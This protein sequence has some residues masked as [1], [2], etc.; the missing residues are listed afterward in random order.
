M[1]RALRTGL[2]FALLLLLGFAPTVGA[3]GLPDQDLDGVS[4]FEDCAP[5][6]PRLTT[7]HTYYIE[8]DGDG[9][10]DAHGAVQHCGVQPFPG[11][12]IWGWDPDDSDNTII[13][14]IVRKNSRVLGL[15]F[16]DS[17]SNGIRA[18]KL[19]R[20]LGAEATMLPLVWSF[21]ESAPGVFDGPQAQLLRAINDDLAADG[22]VA[23]LTVSPIVE[24]QL[25]IPTDLA[26]ALREGTIRFND[27]VFVARFKGLLHF[28]RS[29]LPDL[30]VIVLDIGH[31][32]DR[33][34]V[35]QPDPQFWGDFHHF[36]GQ[37]SPYA[38]ALWG[39][40][41]AIA[42]NASHRGLMTQPSA[43]L[44]DALNTAADVVSVTYFPRNPN[45]TAI[46]PQ[47]VHGQIEELLG[48]Y[49]D[50]AF[51]FQ[52]VGYPTSPALFSSATMQSQFL[53]AFFQVWDQ[54]AERVRSACFTRLYDWTLQRALAE[55][56][57][58]IHG[59]TPQTIE[60]ATAYFQTLGLRAFEGAGAA[61]TG[62]HS[63]RNLAFERNWWR[64]APP[65]SRSFLLGMTP[66]PYDLNPGGPLI[67]EVMDNMFAAIGNDVDLVAHHFD[68]G[69]PWTEA[70]AD[71]F[72]SPELPY[73]AHLK[74]SWAKHRDR[75]PP[76]I[77][78][79]VSVNALGIPRNVLAPYWGFGEGFYHDDNFQA[80][81]TGVFQDYRD[82]LLP[83]PFDSL[84]LDSDVVRTAFLNY[85]RRVI[86][87]YDPDYLITGLEVNLA[88]DPTHPEEFQKVVCL[89]RFIYEQL[90]SDPAYDRVKIVVS[91]VAEFFMSD[92]FGM[93][94]LIDGILSPYLHDLHLQALR[95]IAPYTDVVGLSL[96]PLKTLYGAN[97]T[98]AS[99]VDELFN[100]VR[101][102]TDKPVAITETG[103]GS[104]PFDIR[105]FPFDATEEKQERYLRLL[106]S[107][108]QK[109]GGVEFI[110]N[111]AVRDLTA[112]MEKLRAR[113]LE[114]PPFISATLMEFLKGF[115][116]IGLYDADGN[117]K[118]AT[119]LFHKVFG[120][121]LKRD[122][123]WV[124][125]IS[126]SS[127][128]TDVLAEVSVSADGQLQYRLSHRGTDF[129]ETSPL[130]IVVDGIDL[131]EGVTNLDATAPQEILETYAT[132][133]AHSLAVNHCN[134]V[135]VTVRRVGSGDVAFD[136]VFRVFDDGAAFRYVIPGTG[137]RTI[138]DEST[139]WTLPDGSFVWFQPNTGN[140]E[141]IY[142]G[143]PIGQFDNSM[144]P[145]ATVELPND[146]GF[147]TLTE[148]RLSG[149]S[150]MT[151]ASDLVSRRILPE[152]LD[153]E[154][155][156]VAG[157][158][159]SP[160][161]LVIFSP[162]LNGLVNS[163]MVQNVSPPPDP[164]LFPKGLATDW[165]RPGKALWSFWS[166]F[167][168]GYFYDIQR[169]YVDYAA[170]M[171]VEYVV[172]DA[173]WEVGFPANGADQ[174]DRLAEL[175]N[176]A[177]SDGR[178]IDIWV[179]KNW[180]EILGPA[181]R[182]PF[183]DAVKSAGAVGI[184]ID[185]NAAAE[186]ESQ[187]SVSIYED[188]LRDAAEREL[189]ISFHGNNK[190]TGRERTYPNEITREG[191]AGLELNGVAWE[192]D[193]FLPAQHNAIL[194]FT[195]FVLSP[196]DYTPV[197]FDP[198]KLGNTTFTHQ[199][200][201]A[202]IFTSP[203][204]H[205][206][207]DP[208]ILLAQTDV[209]DVLLSIPTMW[210]ETVVLD[211]SKIGELVAM[212]RR[213]GSDWYLFVLNGNDFNPKAISNLALSFLSGPSYSFTRIAD[214][215]KTSFDR[216]AVANVHAATSLNIELLPGGG[217]VGVFTPSKP[218]TR[219]FRMG[220]TSI[221]PADTELGRQVGYLMLHDNADLVAHNFQEGLPWPEAL[222]SSDYHTYPPNL[223]AHW[224]VLRGS[225]VAVV[226]RHA[227]SVLIN[228]IDVSYD[229]LAPYWGDHN[230]MPLP[231]PWDQ[232]AFNHPNVKQAF[233]NYVIA[234]IEHFQPTFLSIGVEVNILL[235]KRPLQ[236]EAYKELNEH[237]YTTIKGLYPQ[238]TV[239]TSVHYEHMLGLHRESFLLREQLAD[240]YPDVLE[241][242]VKILLQNSDV[243]AVS[244]YP[245]MVA[246]NP[247]L[248]PDNVVAD[249]FDRFYAV[250]ADAGKPLAIDQTGFISEDFYFQP[251]DYTITGSEEVQ[252]NFIGFLLQ[253][254]IDHRF[255]FVVN[256]V[257]IDYGN[258]YG[259]DP[260]TLSWAHA[261]LLRLDGTPKPVLATWNGFL[262]IPHVDDA[263]QPPRTRGVP[264]SQF[265]HARTKHGASSRPIEMLGDV[266][267]TTVIGDA[268]DFALEDGNAARVELLADDML[269]VRVSMTGPFTDWLSG[270]IAPSGL[271]PPSA[272][273]HDSQNATFLS[274]PALSVIV[275][276]HPFR[277]IALR[278]DG[279]VISADADDA[280]G[281][282]P[283]SK[284]LFNRKIALDG[285]RYM[286]LGLRG[287]PIDRRGGD[288]LMRNTDHFGYGEFDGPLYS[289][290]PFYY[291]F[292]DGAFHG[293]FVDSPA[294]PFFD[295]DKAGSGTLTFGA[296]QTELDYY[297]FAGPEPG[298]VARAY[299]R[300]TGFVPLPPKWA[301][302]FH[303]SRYGYNSWQQIA[304]VAFT[305]RQLQIPVDAVYLDLDY[306]NDLDWFSWDPIQFP[307]PLAHNQLLESMGIKRVNILDPSIQPDD[308]LYNFLAQSGYF[309]K[310]G[311]GDVVL[312]EI[313]LPFGQVSWFDYT[314]TSA[315][316]FYMDKLKT[317]LDTGVSGIWNDINEPASNHMPQAIYD[318]DGQKRSDLEARNLYALNN[319]MWTQRAMLEHR[320]N[321]RPFILARSGYSGSQRYN[322]NW[323]GDSLS[324]FDSLRVSVQMSLHM[325]L[326]GMIL[327]GHDI[328]GFLGLPDAELLT[329]WIQFAGFNPYMRNHRINTVA[330]SEPWV[331][332]EPYTSI[333]REA[334][335][336]RY[337]WM[338]YLYSLVE[339]STRTAEPVLTP[340]FF[341]FW[342][343]DPR[344]FGQDTE[345]MLG[346]NVL[347][348]PVFTQGAT[349][350]TLYLPAG[351]DWYDFH[352]GQRY[353]GGRQ[354]TVD[355]PLERIPVFIRAGAVLP[356]GPLTQYVNEP[357]P[358]RVDLDLYPSAAGDAESFTIYED[359]GISFAFR[360]GDYLR[361][362]VT[363]T[364]VSSS[365]D[366][367]IE[368]VE[369]AGLLPQRPWWLR[370]HDVCSRP[371][372]VSLNQAA[373]AAVET[374]ADLQDVEAG[375]FHRTSDGVVLVK[376]PSA[377]LP[378]AIHVGH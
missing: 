34:L 358:P 256:F 318:F 200:A 352:T 26:Q 150:G 152:F 315:G 128:N 50:K 373:L 270:A 122:A 53:H 366:V 169:Q 143:A 159:A 227:V 304:E 139:R 266:L 278:P 28:V 157:G 349:T 351:A 280:I 282:I 3:G 341:H 81:G 329:R 242:E 368:E 319:V 306:M 52:S 207:E 69:V 299:A 285:E 61:K 10:G 144:G 120:L 180:W 76:G 36:L 260:T 331:Y 201:T 39:G 190:P 231:P 118:L 350:R 300:L 347:A 170:Q 323:S 206:A 272:V 316:E 258:N 111:F 229:K 328:G 198:R 363:S 262:G 59:A 361:T 151:Y 211:I 196:G 47:S 24:D 158:S 173:W 205:L 88:I 114:D 97:L 66:H 245:Y 276:K 166:D 40:Q 339:Q 68:N 22:F 2:R 370:F 362:L 303:Q 317:F 250:G 62:Y 149:Y 29:A 23:H 78:V 189:M 340:T 54:N 334:I 161:R 335:N 135:T 82:R 236:W 287:G 313:F 42:V 186:N 297:V 136:M 184:K 216:D 378:A 41:V 279:R 175:V 355:A 178:D 51:A 27:P 202:G 134:E 93:S 179:W 171:G 71:T 49:P 325:S 133:G 365:W 83:P 116:F 102:I 4:D 283:G 377:S 218:A 277:V 259:T 183:F 238:L 43:S 84:D 228:P 126:I 288:Y 172:I 251:L 44:M 372:S 367:R 265:E 15:D 7:L 45:F 137:P 105:G 271:Q 121:P 160:W 344:T 353:S 104:T 269:R 360:A 320:P 374:E 127:P 208:A 294:M 311:N 326:S 20:E 217:F 267:T 188:T 130:G 289:S 176:Y 346:P 74:D 293:V 247:F 343:T 246:K 212:A 220:F 305:F 281:W 248:G 324:T 295:L 5:F 286:G 164:T 274:T 199:L 376:V 67:E 249:Y 364:P 342:D 187:L 113:A 310:D 141:S 57:R 129:I 92:E 70:L 124:P 103:Y 32:V 147:L 9:F 79:A 268:V 369:G 89:Q 131:G 11:S 263:T 21:L 25:T 101:A 237:V 243:F 204:T 48:Q 191:F 46:A 110:V 308:P 291:G 138:T 210:D 96:Y 168:S 35:V 193:Q 95:D 232:Y 30:P 177:H 154:S 356:G 298:D 16:G 252:N 213:K 56:V 106:F 225:D 312:N 375:W 1:K 359:D 197:T 219:P 98:L 148:G 257:G 275:E 33:Y 354:I 314:K 264:R 31:E 241:N 94:V 230:R 185:N 140:Y 235:A 86:E 107:E 165:I 123:A 99:T 142:F 174:F 80:V 100:T 194:P 117:R 55:A 146:A 60:K 234:A 226:P 181:E 145:P 156:E 17:P 222:L 195:R 72:S 162:D 333:I 115:E 327:F 19:A 307:D 221:P 153:D 38:R 90:R 322:A 302:G 332:G 63:L 254:A 6:D 223:Q 132:R 18:P 292:H 309:L 14:Q 192:Y 290:T 87:Y 203:L 284:T 64:V 91:F 330:A 8:S 357:A 65:S 75:H 273:I 125:P 85:L 108:A 371:L 261:G 182:G 73:S 155:W 336:Q 109:H 58:P 296:H 255:A 12:L 348:A 253:E 167:D 112:H 119:R 163:D 321:E 239:F 77:A 338:P 209:L 233:T 224:N 215:T 244:T 337:R 37:V 301:L 13:P 214:A 345:L 240:T